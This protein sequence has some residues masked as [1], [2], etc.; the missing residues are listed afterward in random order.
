MYD[1]DERHERLLDDVGRRVI[2]LLARQFLMAPAAI[3]V[4]VVLPP[5]TTMA[6]VM[7]KRSRDRPPTRKRLTLVGNYD[8]W[9]LTWPTESTA[10]ALVRADESPDLV[11]Y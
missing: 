5:G 10:C 1:L 6:P 2:F 4:A 8:D 11:Q 7:L 9:V 3:C